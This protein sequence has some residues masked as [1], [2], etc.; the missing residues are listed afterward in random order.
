MVQYNCNSETDLGIAV[1]SNVLI[2]ILQRYEI[3]NSSAENKLN[4]VEIIILQI[5]LLNT[6][7]AKVVNSAHLIIDL[8]LINIKC[9]VNSKILKRV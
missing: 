4:L 9:G 8:L 1:A 5:I 2:Q 6:T 3:V 7:T